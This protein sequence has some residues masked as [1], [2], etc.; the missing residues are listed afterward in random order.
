MFAHNLIFG[1]N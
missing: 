1:L